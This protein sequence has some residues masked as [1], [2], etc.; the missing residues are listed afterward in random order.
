MT[1]HATGAYQARW[2]RRKRNDIIQFPT[3]DESYFSKEISLKW[4][5]GRCDKLRRTLSKP[6]RSPFG[7]SAYLQNR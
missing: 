1:P 7:R 6:L 5:T 2:P 3:P 4:R